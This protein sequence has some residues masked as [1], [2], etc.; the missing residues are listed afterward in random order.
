MK[1]DFDL[2]RAILITVEE[3]PPNS[4]AGTIFVEGYDEDTIL[5]H[6]ALLEEAGLLHASFLKVEDSDKRIYAAEVERLTWDGHQFLANARND[7]VWNRT[8]AAV[9]EKG[10]SV[11]F[12][13]FS[14]ILTQFALKLFGI[15]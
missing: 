8:K 4:D 9:A 10:G 1:L 3:S 2:V 12:D 5:E 11:S 15:G 14:A 7:E 6:L 13:I